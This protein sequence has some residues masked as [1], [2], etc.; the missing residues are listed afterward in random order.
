[1][2]EKMVILWKVTPYILMPTLHQGGPKTLT[3]RKCCASKY[4]VYFDTKLPEMH[5]SCYGSEVLFYLVY[6]AEP[7]HLFVVML[8]VT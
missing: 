6:E 5:V 3:L 7:E 2:V 1:M 8:P 4:D